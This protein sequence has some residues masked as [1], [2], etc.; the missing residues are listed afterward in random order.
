MI[1]YHLKRLTVS[2]TAIDAFV[3]I[4]TLCGNPLGPEKFHNNWW[5]LLEEVANTMVP[6]FNGSSY[7]RYP[8]LGGSALSWLDLQMTL[9]PGTEDG[10]ILYNGHRSDGV[11]DFMAVEQFVVELLDDDVDCE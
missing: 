9:K 3:L 7:L 1:R 5:R 11:G 4:R 6:A 2:F 10:V 8:G